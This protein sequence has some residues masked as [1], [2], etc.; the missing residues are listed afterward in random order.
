[1]IFVQGT[2]FWFND[3]NKL[4]LMKAQ[5]IWYSYLYQG[6]HFWFIKWYINDSLL[7]ASYCVEFENNYMHVFICHSCIL[8]GTFLYLTDSDRWRQMKKMGMIYVS[9]S[10]LQTLM[11]EDKWR[12]WEWSTWLLVPY[13]LWWMKTNEEV[14]NDLRES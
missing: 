13:R 4:M 10:T 7:K 9:L 3:V 12:R 1:M 2:H 8:I 6:T 14:G 11:D 5:T